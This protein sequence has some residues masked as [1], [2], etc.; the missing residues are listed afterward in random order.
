MNLDQNFQ[1][2]ILV[3]ELGKIGAFSGSIPDLLTGDS[4]N[5]IS[6]SVAGRLG[7]KHGARFLKSMSYNSK[8][9]YPQN[10]QSSMEKIASILV[11]TGKLINTSELLA[12]PH[13]TAVVGS[14]ALNMNPTIV[15]VEFIPIQPNSTSINIFGTAKEGLIKQ[16]SAEKAVKR[17]VGLLQP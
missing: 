5:A 4:L 2:Q 1:D 9:E 17:I 16:R 6:G 14:G 8:L 3:N 12:T 13:L 11:N 7:A 15:C 10:I